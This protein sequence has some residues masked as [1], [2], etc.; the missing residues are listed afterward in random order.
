[1]NLT[2][3]GLTA[4]V[5]KKTLVEQLQCCLCLFLF[6]PKSGNPL[7]GF[8]DFLKDI[9]AAFGV[10]FAELTQAINVLP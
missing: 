9:F 2:T 10:S 6:F 7:F 4:V 8:S 5:L 1:L 3:S